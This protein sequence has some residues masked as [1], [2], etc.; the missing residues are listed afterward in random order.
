[1]DIS[2][3]TTDREIQRLLIVDMDKPDRMKSLWRLRHQLSPFGYWKTLRDTWMG[4]ES[5]YDTEYLNETLF[6]KTH[7]EC[8]RAFMNAAERA[9]LKNMKRH[10]TIYR[11]CSGLNEEGFSWSL[12]KS[13]AEFFAR[14]ATTDQGQI[15]IATVDRFLVRGYLTGRGEQE[16]VVD[17]WDVELWKKVL[18]PAEKM[19]EH[20]Y[21]FWAAQTG[22]LDVG[23][24][25]KEGEEEEADLW[26]ARRIERLER[27]GLQELVDKTRLK[28]ENAQIISK[29]VSA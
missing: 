3:T 28:R 25:I 29:V 21:M 27:F 12:S 9:E 15:V 2:L 22:N 18:I 19:N 13:T 17:P 6:D 7:P 5:L 4:S 14:R 8:S 10:I 1:M 11:G 16:I 20:R 23:M 24:V 26:I